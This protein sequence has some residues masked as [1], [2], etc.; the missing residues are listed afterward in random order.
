MAKLVVVGSVA[1]DTIKNQFGSV[2]NVLGGSASYGSLAASFFTQPGLVGVVGTDFPQ[3]HMQLFD[4]FGV[5]RKGLETAVGKTFFWSGEYDENQNAK[6]LKIDLGV[7]QGFS[8]NLPEEYKEAEYLF[9]ANIHP[10]LQLSVLEQVKGP[11]FVISDT[12][13]LWI[14]ENRQD[15]LEVMKKSDLFL[16]NAEEAKILTST[17]TVNDAGTFLVSSLGA[18]S[19]IIKKGREGSVLFTKNSRFEVPAFLTD[20]VR[21]TTGAGDCYAAALIAWLAK[22]GDLTEQNIV[23]GMRYGAAIA[24]FTVEDFGLNRLIQVKM[25]DVEKRFSEIKD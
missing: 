17:E 4:R 24:S 7:F 19:V 6:T 25:E 13:D 18:R 22:T 11:K 23:T 15:L 8:P 20:Q 9:L 14:E 12:R 16:I 5:C 3:E 2:E 10:R 1:I 21:D